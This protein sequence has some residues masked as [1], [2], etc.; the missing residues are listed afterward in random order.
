[1][2][3]EKCT[4][5]DNN[6]VSCGTLPPI[7][8]CN[9][10]DLPDDLGTLAEG[11]TRFLGYTLGSFPE[12]SKRSS[13]REFDGTP[14]SFRLQSPDFSAGVVAYY[15]GSDLQAITMQYNYF[16]DDVEYKFVASKQ[17]DSFGLGGGPHVC[18]NNV[19]CDGYDPLGGSTSVGCGGSGW[20]NGGNSD[21]CAICESSDCCEY[22]D[23]DVLEV[24][25]SSAGYCTDD[26]ISAFDV[27]GEACYGFLTQGWSYIGHSGWWRIK[28]PSDEGVHLTAP[29]LIFY[30]IGV[31]GIKVTM[32]ADGN[33]VS[34]I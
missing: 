22:R 13:K 23:F 3:D 6:I 27:E 30:K 7:D 18:H 11:V 31:A 28:I 26:S 15:D 4:D 2:L 25:S 5:P 8:V 29:E 33:V 19:G 1:M 17:V 32:N 21:C 10:F 9:Q 34:G 12:T 14:R 16:I 24:G 20:D